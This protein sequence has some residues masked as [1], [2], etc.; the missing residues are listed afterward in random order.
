M[1]TQEV[2]QGLL[3]NREESRII[4]L[5]IRVVSFTGVSNASPVA[6]AL[7]LFRVSSA[8]KSSSRDQGTH[9]R[10]QQRNEVE[11]FVLATIPAEFHRVALRVRWSDT[12]RTGVRVVCPS[13]RELFW[14][15]P[16]SLS[17][18]SWCATGK[19]KKHVERRSACKGKLLKYLSNPR[20]SSNE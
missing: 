14:H 7:K 19:R 9:Q 10:R 15:L 18:V 13:P 4:A 20:K 8:T 17:F 1:L 12:V 16:I 5:K 11:K 3:S 2:E 6:F